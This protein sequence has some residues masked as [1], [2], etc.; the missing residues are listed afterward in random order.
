MLW[1]FYRRRFRLLLQRVCCRLSATVGSLGFGPKVVAVPPMLFKI[2][3]VEFREPNGGQNERVFRIL[4]VGVSVKVEASCHHRFAVDENHFVMRRAVLGI[5]SHRNP[6]VRDES[7]FGIDLFPIFFVEHRPHPYAPVFGSDERFREAFVRKM[8]RLKVNR[9]SGVLYRVDD[10]IKRP[11][12]RRKLDARLFNVG[13][14]CRGYGS[15][16]RD[17]RRS[18]YLTKHLR[19]LLNF[20]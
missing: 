8:K 13:D 4:P 5:D 17:T 16:D 18:C 2:P 14:V 9:L 19:L 15:Y 7:R 10:G 11:A 20:R 12:L 1:G 6:R 3:T